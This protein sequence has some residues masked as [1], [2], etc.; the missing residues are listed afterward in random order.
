MIRFVISLDYKLISYVDNISKQSMSQW[1]EE[2]KLD[3]ELS[4]VYSK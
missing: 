2:Q 4:P 1:A 3:P